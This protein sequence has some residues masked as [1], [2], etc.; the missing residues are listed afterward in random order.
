MENKWQSLNSKIIYENPWIEVTEHQVLD[1]NG[2][3]GI[4][5]KVHYKNRTAA[6]LAK[7]S[8]GELLIVGQ[9]RFPIDEYSWEIPMGG[10]HPQETVFEAG[11]RELKEETGW[12][13]KNWRHVLTV[14]PS[15]SITD[16]EVQIIMC[17]L[18]VHGSKHLDS[19]ECIATKLMSPNE[20]LN[21]IKEGSIKDAV[22]IT[23]ILLDKN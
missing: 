2:N 16:E 20:L 11:I 7:N 10:I 15:N 9:H 5:G 22:T 19:T 13:A 14:H 17:E 8:N 23:A 4:Y 18:T 3:S 12:S 21:M 1:P 6:I